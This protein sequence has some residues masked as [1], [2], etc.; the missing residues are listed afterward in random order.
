MK[1]L[2][3]NTLLALAFGGLLA[4]ATG[5]LAHGGY[6]GKDGCERASYKERLQHFEQ[7]RAERL[8]RL[9]SALNLTAAQE[10]AWQAFAD[11][12][13]KRP[14]F[15][16]H[17]QRDKS[18]VQ[19]RPVPAPEKFD[20]RVKF[21]EQR[22]AHMKDVS[23]ALHKLYAALNAEQRQTFDSFFAHHHRGGHHYD[24]RHEGR[25]D[26]SGPKANQPRG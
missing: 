21:A 6:A 12:T 15:A 19:A 7:R 13:A 2:T 5:A 20:R 16:G 22:L 9:K 25:G 24:G 10:P 14:H 11:A 23:G 3:R 1:T 4:G 26:G 18:N 17:W 8:A